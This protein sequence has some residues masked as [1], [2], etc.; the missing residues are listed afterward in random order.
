MPSVTSP[1]GVTLR[2]RDGN[3]KKFYQNKVEMYGKYNLEHH[4]D[5]DML[6]QLLYLMLLSYRWMTAIADADNEKEEKKVEDLPAK[7]KSNSTEIRQ[8]LDSLQLSAKTR[9]S[10]REH[11]SVKNY[12]NLLLKRAKV[13]K[14]VKDRK[15]IKA[16]ENMAKM[17]AML[18]MR[19]TC[20]NDEKDYLG[21]H[22]KQI[23][24]KFESLIT[25]Y[26]EIDEKFKEKQK[27]WWME[28]EE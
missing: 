22:P 20:D 17:S 15:T 5:L 27:T 8:I 26:K 2:V 4:S 23:L 1:S 13:F 21:L 14:K 19:R 24:D 16:I 28:E 3:E 10:E 6:D 25:E 11:D 9:Q 12:I 7:V 18:R